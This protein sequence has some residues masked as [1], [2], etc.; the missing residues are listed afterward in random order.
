[1]KETMGQIIRRLRKERNLTQEELAEQLG[2][3]FQAVSKWENDTGMP[4]ISQVVPLAN[5]FGVST[6]VLFGMDSSDADADVEEF[7][8][9]TEKKICNRP[10]GVSE[11]AHHLECCLDVQEKLKQY[12]NNYSLL[13][14]SLG[15]LNNQY[16]MYCVDYWD[17]EIKDKETEKKYWK[18]E[19]IRQANVILKYCT[20]IKYLTEAQYWLVALYVGDGDYDKAEEYI[21]MMPSAR[22]HKK[23]KFLSWIS[24]NRGNREESLKF[25]AQRIYA[26]LDDMSYALRWMANTYMILGK[27]EEA[28]ACY[29]LY[30]DIYDL[31]VG[32]GEEEPPFYLYPPYIDCARMCVK[33]GRHDE[34]LDWLEKLVRH[35]RMCIKN[36]NVIT[37]SKRP[38]LYGINL[39]Y[40]KNAYTNEDVHITEELSWKDYFEPLYDH[41]RYKKFLADAEALERGE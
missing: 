5:V 40:N 3:T 11:Y 36:Y 37:E 16:D 9:A 12:P 22:V 17:N 19:L 15:F 10:E 41:P 7:I 29:R 13:A 1:M 27:Y 24:Y 4:D 25:D 35:E 6:D 32:D 23:E 30:P 33:L 2:V 39:I 38:Y 21:D 26:A 18:N 34:A 28:Y 31:M 8:K 14:Y 20:D